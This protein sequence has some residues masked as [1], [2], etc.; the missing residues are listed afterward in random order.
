MT[1]D[2]ESVGGESLSVFQNP[3]STIDVK[4]NPINDAR[5]TV[6]STPVVENPQFPQYGH[7]QQH[8]QQFHVQQRGFQVGNLE[9]EKIE[10]DER[11]E[12][13]RIV[14]RLQRLN[15][16]KDFPSIMFSEGD[17]LSTLRRLNSVAT[18]AGRAKM[19]IDLMKRCTIFIARVMEGLCERFPNRY[20][21]LQGYSE[22]LMLSIS[23]YDALLYDTYEFY[24]DTLAEMSPLL[25]YLGAIG[26]NLVMYSI[27]RRIMGATSNKKQE[28]EEAKKNAEREREEEIMAMLS[29]R[30]KLAA[31]RR[32]QDSS[33]SAPRDN[34]EN[35]NVE[36]KRAIS[37]SA[38][39]DSDGES[40]G[41]KSVA[42][43]DNA[44]PKPRVTFEDEVT[45][46]VDD[47]GKLKLSLN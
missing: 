15:S 40:V 2:N 30:S 1:D 42:S 13:A 35:R 32:H 47:S 14:Q 37:I 36:S 22:H 17:S 3:N 28:A 9:R 38:P 11:Q 23:Q 26:S 7:G 45:P 12:K 16:R 20:V 6:A 18:S 33:D 43:T 34:R 19:S 24:S 10:A 5:D 39:D 4:H 25:T 21:D 41:F 44:K 29:A 46:Q 27:S 8:Q 31:M